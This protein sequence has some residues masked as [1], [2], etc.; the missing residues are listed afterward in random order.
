[1]SSIRLLLLLAGLSPFLTAGAVEPVFHFETGPPTWRGERIA[2][3]PGFAPDLGWTGVEEIRFAPGMFEAEA[4]DFFSYVLVF[5]LAPGSEVSE[6]GLKRELLAYYR[7]L[8]KAVM[9]GK[10]KTVDPSGFTVTLTKAESPTLAAPDAAPKAEG[11][12]GTLDWIEPFAT[13]KPQKL[14]LEVHVWKE[15]EHPVVLSCVSPVDPG[16]EIAWPA[17]RGIRKTFRFTP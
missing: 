11:W 14:H 13:E 16:A 9:A 7:G 12:T 8:A 5:H 3:P 2:L 10:E 1:M 4:P 6:A 15:G 17:L